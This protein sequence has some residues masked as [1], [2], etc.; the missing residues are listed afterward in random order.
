[1]RVRV[2]TA[3]TRLKPSTRA[4]LSSFKEIK[5]KYPKVANSPRHHAARGA[6]A[7]VVRQQKKSYGKK[8]LRLKLGF[9]SDHS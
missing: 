9:Y 8:G 3:S 5:S 1:M 7:E 2:A 6:M 4:I